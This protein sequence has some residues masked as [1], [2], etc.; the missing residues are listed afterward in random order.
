MSTVIKAVGVNFLGDNLVGLDGLVKSGLIGAYRFT[1]GDVLKDLSGSGNNLTQVGA[2]TQLGN[3][4]KGDKNNGY[5]TGILTTPSMTVIAVFRVEAGDPDSGFAVNNY[6]SISSKG[7][8]LYHSATG[9]GAAILTHYSES[10]INTR[11]RPDTEPY[12]SGE[13]FMAAMSMDAI[14]KKIIH[15]IPSNGLDTYNL[16]ATQNLTDPNLISNSTLKIM[17]LSS[18][19]TW[20]ANMNVAEVLVFNRALTVAE[21]QKQYEYSKGVLG[22]KGISI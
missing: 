14:G 19:G 18:S 2:P 12:A 1:D 8:A 21:I 5:D 16:T 6:N 7:L 20:T 11:Y 9:A 3:Y 22:K 15:G 17:V 10:G 4:V 13:F